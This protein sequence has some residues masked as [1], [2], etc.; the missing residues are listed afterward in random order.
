MFNFFQRVLKE[1][2]KKFLNFFRFLNWKN[3]FKNAGILIVVLVMVFLGGMKNG[4]AAFVLWEKYTDNNADDIGI[5][6]SA[7]KDLNSD[8]LKGNSLLISTS[9][10][11]LFGVDCKSPTK[12]GE[13]KKKEIIQ[14]IKT[15]IE[16]KGYKDKYINLASTTKAIQDSIDKDTFFTKDPIITTNNRDNT[17]KDAVKK[18]LIELKTLFENL[19]KNFSN[20]DEIYDT[21]LPIV[22][23]D[24]DE[25]LDYGGFEK[26]EFLNVF[27]PR[28][29]N[30]S[31]YSINH[32]FRNFATDTKDNLIIGYQIGSSTSKNYASI[33]S[34]IDEGSE[35]YKEF[36]RLETEFEAKK[37]FIKDNEGILSNVKAE[38]DATLKQIKQSI[39]FTL[40]GTVDSNKSHKF[41]VFT[42]L[43]NEFKIEKD[44]NNQIKESIPN[45]IPTG[46]GG[47]ENVGA[48]RC[49]PNT[50]FLSFTGKDVWDTT[51]CSG[52]AY[53]INV[54]LEFIRW[55]SEWLL[56]LSLKFFDWITK[57][58]IYEFKNLV[59]NTGIKEIWSSVI[60]VLLI[61]LVF[62]LM[63]YLVFKS[64]FDN[65][66]DPIQKIL[67]SLLVFSV[68][69][70][71]S[72]TI[73]ATLIDLSNVTS[74]Y[75]YKALGSGGDT[76]G[77]VKNS[78]INNL[79]S[80]TDKNRGEWFSIPQN[81]ANIAVYVGAFIVFLKAS[82]YIFSRALTFLIVLLFS[83][84]LLIPEGILKKIDEWKGTIQKNFMDGLFS[85]PLFFLIMFVAI[86]IASKINGLKDIIG[87][88]ESAEGKDFS[89]VGSVIGS[90]FVL[91]LFF[92][93]LKMIEQMS[94][95]VG[96]FVMKNIQKYGG[97]AWNGVKKGAGAL[98]GNALLRLKNHI[99]NPDKKNTWITKSFGKQGTKWNALLTRSLN[100]N[101]KGAEDRRDKHV[102]KEWDYHKN[103]DEEGKNRNL[104]RIKKNITH[105]LNGRA[106]H[107]TEELKKRDISASRDEVSFEDKLKINDKFKGEVD[108]K[109]INEKGDVTGAVFDVVGKHL[110]DE[111]GASKD[112]IREMYNAGKKIDITDKNG[113]KQTLDVKDE[114]DKI[115]DPKTSPKDRAILLKT[116]VANMEQHVGA[117]SKDEDK[118][119]II[120]EVENDIS[121]KYG[122]QGLDKL[123]ELEGQTLGRIK[124]DPNTQDIICDANGDPQ[125][126]DTNAFNTK[127]IKVEIAEAKKKAEISKDPKD[128]KI[129][130]DLK[131]KLEDIIKDER[132]ADTHKENLKNKAEEKRHTDTIT[133]LK[134]LNLDSTNQSLNNTQAALAMHTEVINGLAD[135][136]KN[137]GSL[138]SVLGKGKGK[139]KKNK[140]GTP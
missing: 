97:K 126:D 137:L 38:F 123:K 57:I 90:L 111:L 18:T 80:P 32:A 20:P 98:T 24:E 42:F 93:A 136:N 77:G 60:V 73:V 120:Q 6:I 118:K 59:E 76:S 104:K 140:G 45:S 110:A 99:N 68:F 85:A 71:F 109:I 65:S 119:R 14:E 27:L 51:G 50:L 101:T 139:G 72:F 117:E 94:G 66:L 115:K 36:K 55:F 58:S 131:Q 82:V 1:I 103:L 30:L 83:P 61:S 102:E 127:E 52:I 15:E 86:Q 7:P 25:N 100:K 48:G 129:L 3:L 23:Q 22:A 121:T 130:A 8:K 116:F 67:P 87:S 39:D 74:I 13:D 69:T 108:K 41:R 124:R 47:G 46:S 64:L 63:L 88:P 44:E 132:G 75:L 9:S 92:F 81:I 43:P 33:F 96:N 62:P 133:T 125:R 53:I 112:I 122:K 114:V 21:Y 84:I 4:E 17:L 49:P 106:T 16:K 79:N 89:W 35:L 135:I 113:K 10:V 70:Y 138:I 31:L 12:I 105:N 11:L 26:K 134:Q 128:Q 54:L 28:Y 56:E 5:C 107:I 95:I 37:A 19:D 29:Y 34:L 91:A 2:N 78:I 40:V